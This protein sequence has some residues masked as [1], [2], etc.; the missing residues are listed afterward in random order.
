[1]IHDNGAAA[2]KNSFS[3]D[4]LLEKLLSTMFSRRHQM[5][6]LNFLKMKWGRLFVKFENL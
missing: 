6:W 2:S 5:S 1:M 4:P 3:S